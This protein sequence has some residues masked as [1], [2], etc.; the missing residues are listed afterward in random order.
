MEQEKKERERTY[1]GGTSIPDPH[2]AIDSNVVVALL[3]NDS[4]TEHLIELNLVPTDG[5]Q[6]TRTELANSVPVRYKD[7]T[8]RSVRR[9]VS[10]SDRRV[11]NPRDVRE[12]VPV[13]L[14]DGLSSDTS[15]GKSRVVVGTNDDRTPLLEDVSVPLPLCSLLSPLQRSL[16]VETSLSSLEG[17][18]SV[19]LGL[20]SLGEGSA[21]A[22]RGTSDRSLV[23][24]GRRGRRRDVA[25]R[26]DSHEDLV[27]GHAC[28]G[29][30]CDSGRLVGVGL[31][32]VG[33]G[34]GERSVGT[35][36]RRGC[37]R[38]RSVRTSRGEGIEGTYLPRHRSS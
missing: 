29:P 35:R 9:V 32:R 36:S 28:G 3:R 15:A 14:V 18:A 12:W 34:V 2:V 24:E 25:V 20:L 8:V 10:S 1:S 27:G 13:D 30:G 17:T 26:G 38:P 21:F 5:T 6:V 37:R 16:A 19:R 22:V 11:G 23:H 33:A 7:A 31:V 4:M